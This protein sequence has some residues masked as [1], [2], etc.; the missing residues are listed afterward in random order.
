MHH[1]RFFQIAIWLPLALI[2][3]LPL[4]ESIS[5]GTQ[6]MQW[7]QILLIYGFSFGTLAYPIFAT[8]ATHYIRQKT[9]R[10]IIRLL[11]WAPLLFIPFY[12]IPWMIYG[13]INIAMGKTS[14]IGMALMWVSFIPYILALGYVFSVITFLIY[15]LFIQRPETGN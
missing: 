10:T 15:K 9:E 14:G 8:W 13:L 7:K 2:L 5:R 1:L 12:G 6:A 4:L 3:S 11:W